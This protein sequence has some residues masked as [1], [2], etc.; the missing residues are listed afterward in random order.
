MEKRKTMKQA[1]DDGK[2][3]KPAEVRIDGSTE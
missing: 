1:A 3:P 2:P